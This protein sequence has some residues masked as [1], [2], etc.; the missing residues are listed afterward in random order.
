MKTIA[1][2]YEK[3]CNNIIVDIS[4]ISDLGKLRISNTL[5]ILEINIDTGMW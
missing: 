3:Y 4:T 5:K 1:C 2:E